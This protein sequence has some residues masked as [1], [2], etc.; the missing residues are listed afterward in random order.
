MD[1]LKA[2]REELVEKED[3]FL[4]LT[5][6]SKSGTLTDGELAELEASGQSIEKLKGEIKTLEAAEERAAQIMRR[7]ASPKRD[8]NPL[9]GPGQDNASEDREL[10]SLAKRFMISNAFKKILANKQIDGVEKEVYEIAANEAK[11]SGEQINGNVAIPQRFI[12]IGTKKSLLDVNT[13]GT[14]V[15]FT[16]YGG[17]VIPYLLPDPVASRI[18]V[19][20]LSGLRGD[21]QWPRND[22]HV[23]FSW[24]TETSDVDET[25][26]TFDNISISPKRV[27]G[28][29][30]VSMQMLKQSIFVVEPFIRQALQNRYALTIDH[31]VFNG[32]GASNEP[33][34]I[35]N[36]NGVNVLS[37]GSSGGTMTYAALLSMMRDAKDA[38]ARMGSE[39]FLTSPYGVHSLATTPRQDS[40]VEGN[41][42]YNGTG[43]LVGVPLFQST[44]V[45]RNFSEGGSGSI[46]T[47]I[48]YS[49]N[50]NGAILGTWGGLDLLFDPYTQAVGGKVRFVCN[51]FMDFEI[52]QPVE[53][54]VCKDWNTTSSL[55]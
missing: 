39:A 11:E 43:P 27:G 37:L 29:V 8:D 7:Q 46:L 10:E 45:P 53:F 26:P 38:D 30:D 23:A 31:A 18:G 36:Y 35:F 50:W 49:P 21:I 55:T 40:G 33:R 20:I 19:N 1:I 28:Y 34:G 42:I 54:S 48:I 15:V 32:L 44:T 51:A 13:E 4:A 22:G 5:N 24:E 52:E 47:G 25:T 9:P 2:K 17:K 41:F 12:K 3:S 6:K 16:E 14:D